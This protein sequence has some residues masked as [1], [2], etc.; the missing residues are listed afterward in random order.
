MKENYEI[1]L[2]DDN[3]E[4]LKVLSAILREEGYQ[5]RIAK[6]GVQTLESVKQSEPDLIILDVQMPNLDGFEVAKILTSDMTKGRVPI[7]FL[8]A[9]GDQ[10][11]ISQ[12]Y[13]AGGDDYI[14]K[15]FFRDEI[16]MKVKSQL[17][18]RRLVLI[19]SEMGHYEF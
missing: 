2:V 16:V 3:V 12:A 15:P 5:I 9:L 1:L 6:D 11:N 19:L 4:N 10:Y 7:I 8:S 13:K 18:Y 14:K 17:K